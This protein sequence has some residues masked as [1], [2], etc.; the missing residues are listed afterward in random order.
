[1][2]YI[3]DSSNSWYSHADYTQSHPIIYNLKSRTSTQYELFPQNN[4]NFIILFIDIFIID[5]L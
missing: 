3:V 2:L 4:S 1:M 5:I